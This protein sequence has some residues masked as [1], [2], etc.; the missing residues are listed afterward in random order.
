MS[1]VEKTERGIT[2]A[3]IIVAAIAFSLVINMLAEVNSNLISAVANVS[4]E[5]EK[6]V[7]RV[8][9]KTVTVTTIPVGNYSAEIAI[10]NNTALQ[11]AQAPMIQLLAGLAKLL[12]NPVILSALIAMSLVIAALTMRGEYAE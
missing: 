7:A 3:T 2:I 4:A 8:A 5:I 1:W 12:T 9:N 10:A 11:V 6:N